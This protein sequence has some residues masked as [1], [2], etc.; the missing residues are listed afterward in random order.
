MTVVIN[1]SQPIA[2]TQQNNLR[3]LE[4]HGKM[5]GL[6]LQMVADETSRALLKISS[7]PDQ[8]ENGVSLVAYSFNRK[9]SYRK[10]RI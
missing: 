4:S 9:A 6:E 3:H 2:I 8:Y 5:D 7:S 1:C 10:K